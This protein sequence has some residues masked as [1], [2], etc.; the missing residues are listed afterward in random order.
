MEIILYVARQM[1]G[2]NHRMEY[3]KA[4]ILFHK[5]FSHVYTMSV[6]LDPKDAI[7]FLEKTKEKVRGLTQHHK[8]R[9]K[10]SSQ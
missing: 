5:I 2:K 7:T 4:A 3:S 1:H 8:L 9:C 10:H 6:F